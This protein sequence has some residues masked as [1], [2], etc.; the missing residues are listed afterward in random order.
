[1]TRLEKALQS[2][3]NRAVNGEIETRFGTGPWVPCCPSFVDCGDDDL[4]SDTATIDHGVVKGCR[5]ITCAQCW[6][7]EED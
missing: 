7:K 4:D 2:E 6:N 1:M 3:E 5:G